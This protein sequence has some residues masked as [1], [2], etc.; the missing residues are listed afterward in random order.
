MTVALRRLDDDSNPAAARG[1]ATDGPATFVSLSLLLDANS[2]ASAT[3]EAAERAARR[4]AEGLPKELAEKIRGCWQVSRAALLPGPTPETVSERVRKYRASRPVEQLN[5]PPGFQFDDE[6]HRQ[7]FAD[8]QELLRRERE[9]ANEMP[10]ATARQRAKVLKERHGEWARMRG[11]KCD[12]TSLNNYR[13]RIN[14]VSPRFDGNRD[15]R[16]RKPFEPDENTREFVERIAYWYMH[17]NQLPFTHCYRNAQREWEE[18]G[19][20]VPSESAARSAFRSQYPRPA[21]IYARRG[22]RKFE[23]ECLPKIERDYTAFQAGERYEIDGHVLDV[24]AR[25]PD[26]RKGW[27]RCRPTL[28]VVRDLRSRRVAGWSFCEN[29][30]A[31]AACRAIAMAL[32]SSGIPRRFT[33]D[34]GPGF[35]AATGAARPKK[36]T[37][38]DDERIT[39]TLSAFNVELHRTIA[40]S[41]WSKGAMERF[42]GELKNHFSRLFPS[43]WGG[44]PEERPDDADRRTRERIDLLPTIADLEAEFP[45]F[46]DIYHATPHGGDGMFG[47]SPNEVWEQF[48]GEIRTADAAAIDLYIQRLVGPV[49]VTRAGVRWGNVTFGRWSEAVFRLQGQKVMLRIDPNRGDIVTLCDMDGRALCQASNER[50]CGTTQDDVRAAARMRTKM[51]RAMKAY[52][53]ARNFAMRDGVGQV[54]AMK[55]ARANAARR[56]APPAEAPAVTLVRPDLTAD[57]R[58]VQEDAAKRGKSGRRSNAEFPHDET[59]CNAGRDWLMSGPMPGLSAGLRESQESSDDRLAWLRGDSSLDAGDGSTGSTN[60]PDSATDGPSWVVEAG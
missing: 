2:F 18:A 56:L 26:A 54:L 11:L 17:K 21:Q 55:A 19:R 12:Y 31:D 38:Y 41:P 50:L 59:T 6:A 8:T 28:I 22:L 7:R 37:A 3:P 5:V 53:P 43:F 15:G 34:N 36:R 23:A 40:H 44:K 60:A 39:R 49:M 1:A 35:V 51:R 42:F 30:N 48:R 46:L 27:R 20:E 16:G 33:L 25:V 57:A 32:K 58:R 52:F 4:W 14:P 10:R 9:I 45:K 29:E 24:M 47:L 13:H